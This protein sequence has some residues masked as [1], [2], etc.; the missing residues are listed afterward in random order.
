MVSY[1]SPFSIVSSSLR[2]GPWQRAL[3][4]LKRRTS[5]SRS[6]PLPRISTENPH[7][8]PERHAIE[9]VEYLKCGTLAD[10]Y[11][12]A[13]EKTSQSIGSL[14][15]TGADFT[16]ISHAD[17]GRLPGLF[18]KAYRWRPKE[19]EDDCH[20]YVRFL[21]RLDSQSVKSIPGSPSPPAA[22]KNEIVL[23][24]ET[25]FMSTLKKD[26]ALMMYNS[27]HHECRSYSH[28]CIYS[29]DH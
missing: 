5:Y 10:Y 14:E 15:E 22:D 9:L 16:F 20:P 23:K 24:D 12:T 2:T 29:R 27:E 26:D 18:D 7:D 6:P 19:P 1:L 28:F 11:I 13:A 17:T 21:K 25:S 3:S 8:F 4:D